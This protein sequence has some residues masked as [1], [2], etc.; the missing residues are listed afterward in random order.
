MAVTS[1]V[2][3]A[4][5][6]IR[7][8]LIAFYKTKKSGLHPSHWSLNAKTLASSALDNLVMTATLTLVM[9]TAHW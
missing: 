1:D 5:C 3:A 7:K 9:K 6:N 8:A 2:G 4:G